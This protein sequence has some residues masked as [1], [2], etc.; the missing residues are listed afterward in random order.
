MGAS[1]G[2][3]IRFYAPNKSKIRILELI[4][5]VLRISTILAI[6]RIPWIRCQELPF[7]PSLD[8][9]GSQDDVS[10]QATFRNLVSQVHRVLPGPYSHTPFSSARYPAH[11]PAGLRPQIPLMGALCPPDSRMSPGAQGPIP[12]GSEDP[13]LS[14][15]PWERWGPKGPMAP[16]GPWAP[17]PGSL[18]PGRWSLVPGPRSLAPGPGPWSRVPVPGS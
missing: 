6:L 14:G 4:S 7:R 15:G 16:R 3:Q 1:G 8:A 5:G 18:A 2:S 11:L 9:L 10:S 13:S 17:G 12:Q